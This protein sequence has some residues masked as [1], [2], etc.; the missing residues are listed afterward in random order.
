[1]KL[2]RYLFG[3]FNANPEPTVFWV[4]IVLGVLPWLILITGVYALWK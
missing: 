3:S 2:L 1:M 4:V